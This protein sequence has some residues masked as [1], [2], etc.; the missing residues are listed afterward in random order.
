M[1]S[2]N[3]CKTTSRLYIKQIVCKVST[4]SMAKLGTVH[5]FT[6]GCFV[7]M[8]MCLTCNPNVGAVSPIQAN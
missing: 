3:L 6:K 4:F 5:C 1:I 8:T 7:L 2:Q